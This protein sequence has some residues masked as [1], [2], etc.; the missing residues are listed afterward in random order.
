[1]LT[2]RLAGKVH[3]QPALAGATTIPEISAD[4]GCEWEELAGV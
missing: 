3:G 1:M 4:A 2:E